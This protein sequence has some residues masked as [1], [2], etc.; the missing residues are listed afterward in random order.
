MSRTADNTLFARAQVIK[1]IRGRVAN[2][3][4]IFLLPLIFFL[5]ILL[6]AQQLLASVPLQKLIPAVTTIIL[7]VIL[8]VV[9]KR[10]YA[11]V[12]GYALIVNFFF[13]LITQLLEYESARVGPYIYT[14]AVI[15]IWSSFLVSRW[16]SIIIWFVLGAITIAT[17][18]L[19]NQGIFIEKA[20]PNQT[21]VVILVLAGNLNV[22]ISVQ[23][24]MR[25]LLQSYTEFEA[26]NRQ[27][28]E[29]QRFTEQ[30]VNNSQQLFGWLTPD[31]RM[32]FANE[33]SLKVINATLDDVKGKLFW[34]T[35][36]FDH[37][38]AEQT[39]I[40]TGIEA[41][42]VGESVHFETVHCTPE[43]ERRYFDFHIQPT[44][45]ELGVIRMIVAESI[46]V[47]EKR[48][49]NRA[50]E[51]LSTSFAHLYGTEFFQEVSRYI[52]ANF[53]IDCVYIG[54]WNQ[55]KNEIQ[56]V[57]G[58]MRNVN[59]EPFFYPVE[60]APCQQVVEKGIPC[61]VPVDL[62]AKFQLSQALRQERDVDAYVGFPLN[63]KKGQ[64]IGVIVALHTH[65]IHFEH[66]LIQFFQL[67][68]E[69]VSSEMVRWRTEQQLAHEI[70]QK[71][72]FKEQL[73]HSQ[74]M[75]AIG[76]LA[77]G[78]AHDFNNVLGGILSAVELLEDQPM[79]DKSQR[80]LGII[81]K[82]VLR[83][84]GLTR[85]LLAFSRK[86][87]KVSSTVSI[88][89]IINDTVALLKR[90]INKNISIQQ[91][92]EA[93]NDL[94]I[95]DDVLIQNVLMN[96]GINASH[97]MKNG[98][99]LS[100]TLRTVELD[101][102]YC[103]AS[104][105]DLQPGE[106]LELTARDTGEGMSAETQQRIFEP[107]FTTKEQGKGT[108]LGLSTAYGVMQEHKGAITVYSELGEGTA[109]R[110]YFPIT[111]QRRHFPKDSGILAH[112][113]YGT[114]LFVDDEELIRITAK[115]QL[116]NM[117]YNV[118]LANNGEEA[119]A[120]FEAR[121][122]EI[123]AIILDMIMPIMD[124]RKAAQRIRRISLEVP[125]LI[126]SGFSKEKDLLA[127]KKLNIN[128]FL[129]KPLQKMELCAALEEVFRKP[130]T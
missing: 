24:A 70:E 81:H 37:D 72:V 74:K 32:V 49:A 64:L 15:L 98:G 105:F 29:T 13:A 40:R 33:T 11:L 128:K 127:L 27:L 110:L 4:L 100:F 95:G 78:V 116:N 63:N 23:A 85:Q 90:T 101:E 117:G 5:N 16:G 108:G 9:R 129:Q 76:Q 84:G 89:Q 59:M 61:A 47:T 121:K 122:E 71:Q 45:D 130:N 80:Y 8:W 1:N 48:R 75:D 26:N 97:A 91:N 68:S 115:A 92:L 104:P 125:I 38:S 51:S 60:N 124:G 56:I 83:A 34:E 107:F 82:A 6:L 19:V 93:A 35:P 50:L 69:R 118:L 39:K 31:G 62:H 2:E 17:G 20:V 96:I 111:D 114:I 30:A 79:D 65:S 18:Y 57:G 73:L 46:D 106:F 113:G 25:L 12:S 66:D 109:F 58:C 99:A 126:S 41:A 3:M 119:L 102:T 36:W 43:G 54:E 88:N 123:R 86:G 44:T 22:L 7:A 103:A 21:G 53:G 77:G 87:K 112:H 55:A 14:G 52:A 94:V 67:F 10:G 42:R 28:A 120:L